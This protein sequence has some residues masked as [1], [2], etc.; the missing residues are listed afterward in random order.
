[1][2]SSWPQRRYLKASK[3]KSWTFMTVG[4]F[5]CTARTYVAG[6][7]PCPPTPVILYTL[8]VTCVFCNCPSLCFNDK[9][10]KLYQSSIPTYDLRVFTRYVTCPVSLQ[11]FPQ[12]YYISGPPTLCDRMSLAF[13]SL[14]HC[15]CFLP[16]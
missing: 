7:W 5:F 4:I 11:V 14:N 6:L 2:C 3:K 16:C 10:S 9:G 8:S 15:H 12:W 1:M 13:V